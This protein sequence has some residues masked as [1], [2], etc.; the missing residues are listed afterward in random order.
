MDNNKEVLDRLNDLAEDY[1]WRVEYS[2]G[3]Y[4]VKNKDGHVIYFSSNSS[5]V[6]FYLGGKR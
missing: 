4:R 1:G 3:M 5:E 2:N 6:R